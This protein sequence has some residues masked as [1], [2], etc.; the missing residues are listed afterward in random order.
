MPDPAFCE[1]GR[2][3][4][5]VETFVAGK[6]GLYAALAAFPMPAQRFGSGSLRLGSKISLR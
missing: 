2:G 5:R 4:E 6:V 1:H 3:T